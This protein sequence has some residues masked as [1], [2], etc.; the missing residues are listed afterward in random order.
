MTEHSS[1]D[2]HRL[3]YHPERVAAWLRGEDIYPIY[4]EIG[5]SSRCNYRCSFCALDYTGYK[6]E[7]I[8]R[9]LLLA[10]L[11]DMAHG[12]VKSVMFAGAGESLTHPDISEFI[13]KAKVSGMD[14][15]LTTNGSLLSLDLAKSILP[16]LSWIRFSVN[17]GTKENYAAIHGCQEESFQ[18]VLDNIQTCVDLK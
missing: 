17:A 13:Q 1:M 3:M 18:T 11:E 9:K 15:A 14:V 2:S 7:L 12:G 16:N 8:P 4:V 10:S 5:P 6:G